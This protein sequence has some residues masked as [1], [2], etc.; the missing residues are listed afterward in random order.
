MLNNTVTGKVSTVTPVLTE[1]SYAGWIRDTSA[2]GSHRIT[3]GVFGYPTITSDFPTT[4]TATYTARVA[5]RAVGVGAGGTG[6]IVK[7]GG[8]VTV[9]VN[10]ATG[11]VSYTANV[12]QIVGGVETAYGTYSG[13]GAVPAGSSQFSGSFGAGSPIPGTFT[14]TL[15]G[16]QG[17]ELGI[18]FA[19]AG[20]T[21]GVDTRIA[22][23]IVGKKN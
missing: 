15:F 4:G 7:L 12:T 10:F 16:S 2:T 5:G 8:T 21:G 14:G 20:T 17:A 22:G 1:V 6:T 19:G 13:S 3:Y 23:V 11:A 9:T 18:S